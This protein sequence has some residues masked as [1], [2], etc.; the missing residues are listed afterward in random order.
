MGCLLLV[1]AASNLIKGDGYREYIHILFTDTHG[2]VY[3]P[4][5]SKM[6]CNISHEE[7]HLFHT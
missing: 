7:V 6:A 4:K 5:A 1:L 3:K 2:I